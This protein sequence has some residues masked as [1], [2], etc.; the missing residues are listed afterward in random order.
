MVYFGHA[1]G[2]THPDRLA[3]IAS[4]HG[5]EPAPVPA[6]RVLEL[7]CAD[8][9]NLIPMAY[10]W[11][12]SE[13]VGIDLSERAIS[14][15][16][17]AAAGLG[18]RNIKLLRLDI[19]EIGAELGRFDYII[20]HGVY[21]WVPP[22]VR[23]KMMAVFRQNLA[24]AGVA[25][26]SYNAYPGSHL[27]DM[28]REMML[29]HVR[30]IADPQTRVDQARALLQRLAEASNQKELYG[31][32]LH[33][34]WERVRKAPDQ[35]LYHDD[36]D[37]GA[38]A[39]FLYQ[40]VEEAARHGLQYLSDASLSLPNLDI[41]PE[42]VAS[43]ISQIPED[44]AMRR[45][46][47][48][49]FIKGR[50]FRATLLCH[51]EA[52][53]QRRIAPQ[54]IQNYHIAAHS[55]PVGKDI[56]PGETGIAEFKTDEGGTIS[57]DHGLSKAALLHL[58]AAWPQAVRFPELVESA[59]A[60]IGA[61][62]IPAGTERQADIEALMTILFRM[63]G[64]GAVELHLYPPRLTTAIGERPKASLLAR[65]QATEGPMITNLRHTAV[66]I[67]DEIVRRFLGLVDGTRSLDQIVCDLNAAAPAGGRESDRPQITRE[68]VE[69]NL[70]IMARL[71]LLIA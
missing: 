25:Y 9:G 41:E 49:D 17:A 67:E 31:F 44:D 13:F 34:Q 51:K 15:A 18:L 30:A 65:K 29:F 32:L 3:T 26:V 4:L 35:R 58:A 64:A 60:L 21:S 54:C 57:T 1:F 55:V 36:L 23:A 56:D 46:Q 43:M 37:E 7:G 8:G 69:R 42:P 59:Y 14:K 53:L 52:R 48:L 66:L 24:P 19:L 10:Q 11:P 16:G 68:E 71:G 39:F 28:A 27:R 38:R 70:A 5:M 63:V 45:E 20:A 33:D 2:Q 22:H 50:S 12:D 40:V 61:A 6:C 47:Y 62:A